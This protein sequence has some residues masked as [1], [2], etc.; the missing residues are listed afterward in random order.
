MLFIKNYTLVPNR[1]LV[2]DICFGYCGLLAT[3]SVEFSL[4]LLTIWRM[5]SSV[6]RTLL[7]QLTVDASDYTV[8]SLSMDEHFIVLILKKRNVKLIY[9]VATQT[10]DIC[11]CMSVVR[12]K[13]RY[14]RGFLML[15]KPDHIR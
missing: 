7:R 15:M 5:N 3:V 8:Q 11:N 12:H 6:P 10:F 13:V 2:R 4:C 14:E 1:G 9:F